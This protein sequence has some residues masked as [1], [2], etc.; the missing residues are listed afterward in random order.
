MKLVALGG[1]S[2]FREILFLGFYA[3]N[4]SAIIGRCPLLSEKS[5]APRREA[6]LEMA[7]GIGS[8]GR[9]WQRLLRMQGGLQAGDRGHAKLGRGGGIAGIVQT[10]DQTPRTPGARYD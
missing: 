8:A 6:P 5:A 1:T 4:V 9:L 10:Q 2:F 3:A 7:C